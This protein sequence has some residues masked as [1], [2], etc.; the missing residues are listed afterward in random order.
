MAKTYTGTGDDGT[1]SHPRSG[2]VDKCDEAIELGGLFDEA[3][4]AIG[5]AL[6]LCNDPLFEEFAPALSRSMDLLFEYAIA[7]PGADTIADEVSWIEGETDHLHEKLPPLTTFVRPTG[8]ELACRLHLARVA[9]RRL[10][11]GLFRV[12]NTSMTSCASSAPFI[13]RLSDY[14]FVAARRANELAQEG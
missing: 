9:V 13:N 11:R 4:V 8:C 10:E 6:S 14:L 7:A 3:Q 2:R 1:T 12:V 5:Y